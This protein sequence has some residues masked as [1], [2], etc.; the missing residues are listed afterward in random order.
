MGLEEIESKLGSLV[1]ADTISQLKSAVW[2]ERLEAI[3]SFKQQVEGLSDLDHWVE[4]LICLLCAV[5]GWSEK[6]VQ[7]QQQVIE[8]V[9]FIAS[10]S[11]KFP[12][13]CVVLCL[14]GISERVAD[15]KTRAH[16]MKCLTTFCEAVG[17]GFIFEKPIQM[18]NPCVVLIDTLQT[19]A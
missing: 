5:P 9:T 18:V 4:L 10:S 11:T 17:P 2:K 7:V 12:K 8:V 16:A 15:I 6:N 1:Q 19:I 3:S 13:K 14:L